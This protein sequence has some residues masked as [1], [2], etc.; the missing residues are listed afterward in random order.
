MLGEVNLDELDALGD[1][2]SIPRPCEHQPRGRR[3]FPVLA[4]AAEL[5]AVRAAHHQPQPA[6]DAQVDLGDRRVPVRARRIPAAQQ[7][8]AGPGLEHRPRRRGKP[9]LDADRRRILT[10]GL[11]H[12]PSFR[13]L[14]RSSAASNIRVQT[15][16]CRSNHSAAATS[17]TTFRSSWCVR[18]STVRTTTP[19]R[20]STF[21]CFE[22]VGFETP[23]PPVTTPTVAGPRARRSTIPRRIGWATALNGS[24]A[25]RLTIAHPIA[26]A[27]NP[28]PGECR[29]MSPRTRSATPAGLDAAAAVACAKWQPT[30]GPLA[31]P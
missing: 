22:I 4:A 24:L 5:L 6:A 15:T 9:A 3:D 31:G 27:L 14:S 16:R 12:G 25:I 11:G 7:L 26:M 29:T 18:P 19:A 20:S 13:S 8:C 2:R 23:K 21:R 28:L 1:V 17:G 30:G 10:P